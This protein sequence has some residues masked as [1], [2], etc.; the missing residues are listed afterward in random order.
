MAKTD[1]DEYLATVARLEPDIAFIDAC[2]YY[3]SAAISLKRIADVLE[4]SEKRKAEYHARPFQMSAED[5]GDASEIIGNNMPGDFDPM[6]GLL[7]ID[8]LAKGGFKVIRK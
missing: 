6:A 8:A 1:G 5:T 7:I 4:A 2:A 3:A